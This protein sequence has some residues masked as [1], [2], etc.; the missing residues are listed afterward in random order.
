[1]RRDELLEAT[2]QYMLKNGV[3]HLSLRPLA[4]AIGTK[5]RLLI[6][7]FGS[8]DALVAA[9]LSLALRRVQAEFLAMS[10]AAT[11]DRTLIGFWRWATSAESAPYLRLVF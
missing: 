7:H 2:V 3:S 4:K 9:A 8:R 6:Y 1:M 11:L 5:A 10:G